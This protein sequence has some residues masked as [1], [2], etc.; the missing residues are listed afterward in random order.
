MPSQGPVEISYDVVR[1]DEQPPN[2]RPINNADVHASTPGFEEHERREI[3][4]VWDRSH[5]PHTMPKHPITVLVVDQPE[6]FWFSPAR[7]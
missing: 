1:R 5:K 4:S 6:R 7:A 3:L 2:D